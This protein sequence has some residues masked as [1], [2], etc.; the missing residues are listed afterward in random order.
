MSVASLLLVWL[1]KPR[2]GRSPWPDSPHDQTV[3]S[4]PS[5]TKGT[6]EAASPFAQKATTVVQCLSVAE[7]PATTI[8]ASK[9]FRLKGE[10]DE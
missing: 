4:E 10:H 2:C 5:S 9:S 1:F 7:K 3:A 6:T 8:Q